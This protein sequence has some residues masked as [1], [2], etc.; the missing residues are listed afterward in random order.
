MANRTAQ[1]RRRRARDAI[2]PCPTPWKKLFVSKQDVG[3]WL[4]ANPIQALED[5]P[6]PCGYWHLR[7]RP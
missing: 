6:C 7:T 3:N 5:Y 2:T 4:T 1:R